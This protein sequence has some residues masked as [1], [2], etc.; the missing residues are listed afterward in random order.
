MR[1][2]IV[3]DEQ[4]ARERMIRIIE[5]LE[6]HEIVGEAQNGKEA[7]EQIQRLRPD[8]VILDI[9]MPGMD[10]LEVARHLMNLDAPPAIIFST[11]YDEHAMEAFRVNAVDYLLKPV[12]AEQLEQALAKAIRPSKDQITAINKEDKGEEHARLYISTRD[13]LGITLIAFEDIY[14]FRAED[15]YVT[16][17]HKGGE[18]L[19]DDSLKD[20]EEEFA[21][22]LTRIHRNALVVMRHIKGIEKAPGGTFTLRLFDIPD[23]LE[24][25]RRHLSKIRSILR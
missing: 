16:V 1:I 10:G 20:L 23:K 21:K 13:R 24:I 22:K 25:S 5:Q 14:Y 8:V 19:I 17:R 6:N 3:D 11:A 9:R 4:L 7:L 12:R 15:K 18:V 2:L